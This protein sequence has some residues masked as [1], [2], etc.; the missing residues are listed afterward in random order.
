MC[1]ECFLWTGC[2]KKCFVPLNCYSIEEE[3]VLN[4][5]RRIQYRDRKAD[6]H[7]QP[8]ENIPSVLTQRGR[9]TVGPPLPFSRHLYIM[10]T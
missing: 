5:D 2:G 10:Q 8:L 4:K 3:E 9:L 7:L 6:L 1:K